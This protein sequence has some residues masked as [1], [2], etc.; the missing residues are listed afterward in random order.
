MNSVV[1]PVRISNIEAIKNA[2]PYVLYIEWCR[3]D[4]HHN[5]VIVSPDLISAPIFHAHT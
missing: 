5:S 3:Q 2:Y 1:N 4:A